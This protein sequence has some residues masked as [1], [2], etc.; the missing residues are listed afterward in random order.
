MGN[1]PTPRA[2]KVLRGTDRKDRTN[3]NEPRPDTL[4][5]DA[6]PPEWLGL[7]EM[8]QTAWG[9]LLPVLRRMG[10]LTVADPIA[11]A[12]LCDALAEYVAAR[13]VV[14]AEGRTYWT[15]GKVEM[16]RTRPEVAIAADAWRRAKVMLG[17]F[18]LTPA[19]RG[20]VSGS[21]VAADD[22]LAAWMAR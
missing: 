14:D 22:P 1:P 12:M 11:L 13:T 7:N 21:P 5:A 6:K 8:A 17:E 16:Q 19:T 20:R 2:L 9:D 3:P 18:G 15:R 10:V 4:S